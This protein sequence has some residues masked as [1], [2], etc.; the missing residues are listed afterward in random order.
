MLAGFPDSLLKLKGLTSL[1]VS[2]Q[3]V[4]LVGSMC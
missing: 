1:A 4:R 3:G 2:S